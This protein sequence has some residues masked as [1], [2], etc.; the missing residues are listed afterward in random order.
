[1]PWVDT[2]R[3]LLPW[4]VDFFP[5]IFTVRHSLI[6]HTCSNSTLSSIYTVPEDVP[7]IN[8]QQVVCRTQAPF[9]VALTSRFSLFFVPAFAVVFE[10]AL[11]PSVESHVWSHS[12]QLVGLFNFTSTFAFEW[13]SP[14]RVARP[15]AYNTFSRFTTVV[16]TTPNSRSCHPFWT[17]LVHIPVLP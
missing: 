12:L 8:Q 5:F 10:P 14:R 2:C 9:L 3:F 17:N 1:M 11:K 4:P 16:F 6:W 13:T 15:R 7:R